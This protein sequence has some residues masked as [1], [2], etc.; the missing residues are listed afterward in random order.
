MFIP[1][2]LLLIFNLY[3]QYKTCLIYYLC[4]KIVLN[5]LLDIL[6]DNS[7]YKQLSKLQLQL[8]KRQVKYGNFV[9]YKLY[10]FIKIFFSLSSFEHSFAY[11]P[12][13]SSQVIAESSIT[14]AKF[15]PFSQLNVAGFQ[16]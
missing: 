16:T 14:F 5:V 11:D 3:Y 9:F 15:S 6:S 10:F 4:R 1:L 7:K 13:T 8:I 12:I 2:T